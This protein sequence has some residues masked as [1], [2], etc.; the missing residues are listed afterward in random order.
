MTQKFGSAVILLFSLSIAV[1]NADTQE[2][3]SSNS[4]KTVKDTK[5]VSDTPAS[6]S[7]PMFKIGVFGTLGVLHSTQST[8]D[9]VLES[10]MPSGAGRSNE[11]DINNYSKLGVQ[12]NGVFTPNVSG[13]FQVI[14]AYDSNGSFQ[15]E[16]EWV[17]LKYSFNRDAYVRI[18][19]IG[20][21]TFFDSGN[22]DVGY[23][24]TWAHPPSELYYLLPILSSDGID[25]MYRLNIG[26]TQNSIK[27]FYGTNVHEGRYTSL[28]SHG[29]WGV[30]D[31]VEYGQT[32]FH[33]NYQ[34]RN[35]TTQIIQT[36]LTD[37]GI[38]CT[39]LSIG[40]NYEADDWFIMSEWIQSRTKYTTN[41]M[42]VGTGY[43]LNKFTP[44]LVHSQN[45]PGS[46]PQG[47]NPTAIEVQLAN[48]SQQT[49]SIG[50]RWDFKKNFDLKFQY[51]QVT[52]SDNSNGFLANVPGFPA[53]SPNTSSYGSNF[54]LISA[55][56]DFVF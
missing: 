9:Y 15:P 41:A 7:Q 24:Y 18:G 35:T 14:T 21:P 30:S 33:V 28:T 12:L 45:T 3:Q 51:D 47:Y 53:G 32:T 52:L 48:R 44:Y 10:S 50:L 11:W 20:L 38:D 54:S 26:Q 55:V 25:A 29:M 46:F 17:N 34:Q 56:M 19:R 23:S 4:G 8:G 31:S 37:G 22:H 1:A 2:T 40:I 5:T 27:V 6:E 42:Y 36:G 39:D 16:V 13:Q 49:N 43:H